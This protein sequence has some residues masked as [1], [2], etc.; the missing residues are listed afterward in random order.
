MTTSGGNPR[1]GQ[2]SGMPMV[3]TSNFDNIRKFPL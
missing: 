1:G 3:E 2:S